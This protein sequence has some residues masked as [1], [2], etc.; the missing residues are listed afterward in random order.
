MALWKLNQTPIW[1]D[2]AMEFYCSVL[3]GSPVR[4]VTQYATM[5]ER[6]AYIQQQPPLYNWIMYLWLKVNEGEWWFRFSSVIFGFVAAIGIYMVLKKLCSKKV[7]ILSVFVFSSL[8]PVMYYIKEASEYSLLL[9]FMAWLV[10]AFIIVIENINLKNIIAFTVLCVLTVYTHYS[11]VFVV[12]PLAIAVLVYCI[13]EKK[14]KELRKSLIAYV[15]A[16][17][18]AGLPLIILFLI[19]QEQHMLDAGGTD[20]PIEIVGGNIVA[21]FFYSIMCVLRW[22]MLDYDRDGERLTYIMWV[23]MFVLLILG[24]V[25][26]IRTRK[27]TLRYLLASNVAI[28]VIYYVI[29][30]LNIYS[31]GWYGNRY[32]MFTIPIWLVIIFG[33]IYEG[34]ELIKNIDKT[35][36]KKLAKVAMIIV[37]IVSILYCLYGVK[38]VKD[39][40]WKSDLRTVVTE[41][42]DDGG[43][44]I[45]TYVG[46]HLRY[47]FVYYMTHND[48]YTEDTW[49]NVWCDEN[50][51]TLDF[52]SEEW[53]EYLETVVYPDGLPDKL[54]VV[55]GQKHMAVT[56]LEDYGYNVEPVVDSTAKLFLLT[57]PDYNNG[58]N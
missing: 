51:D 21:D 54:Y 50:E 52:N 29:V 38:R 19:P 20:K 10:Y 26:F 4:G 39:H 28:F 53:I 7:A 55:L 42:Y 44:E 16:A 27:K 32:N 5:Y 12:V 3:S 56:A 43:E 18:C 41:W 46:Y 36:A 37:M 47:A 57:S 30:K 48:N 1:Q 25:V 11:G 58:D 8:Y 23:L 31:Y 45:P 34:L 15:T 13:K 49:N 6:M 2:E 14:Y 40:W 33:I 17:V 24:I 35:T 9:M 22:D